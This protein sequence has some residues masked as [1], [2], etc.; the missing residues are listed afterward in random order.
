MSVEFDVISIGALAQNRLWGEA[1]A[2]RTSHATTT[3]VRTGDRLILVDPSLPSPALEARFFERTGMSLTKVTDV[4]CTT[5]RPTHRRNAQAL[6]SAKWWAAE[7]EI[8]A[9]CQ[10]LE[11][12]LGSAQR[13][14]TDDVQAAKADLKIVQRFKPAPDK[15]GP[16][17]S[18]YPL[19]GPSAGSSGLLLTPATTTVIIAGDA[20]LTAGHVLAGQIWEGCGDRQKALES[21]EDLLQIADI[22]VPG[23]DNVMFCPQRVV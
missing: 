1:S 23:H 16:Q 17:V 5:L 19:I 18:L 7:A 22:I 10:A 11:E 3:L 2:V 6:P 13:L 20:A 4:F 15:F 14:G 8:D 9:A 21:L 12:F